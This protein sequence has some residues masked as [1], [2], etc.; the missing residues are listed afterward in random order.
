MFLV[1][2]TGEIARR[3]YAAYKASLSPERLRFIDV[4]AGGD[5]TGAGGGRFPVVEGGAVERLDQP[6]ADVSGVI[7]AEE[8]RNIRPEVMERLV[9]MHFQ[10]M[11]VYTLES[12]YETQWRRVPVRNI[13]PSWP[14][15]IGFQLA[16]EFAVCA[17][18]AV[19]RRGGFRRGVAGVQPGVARA[20]DVDVA[21][22]WPAGVVPAAARGPGQP[23]VH[24][25]QVPHD[26]QLAAARR[27]RRT[28]T[29]AWAIRASRGWATGCA[30]CVWTSC[31]S[32]FNV[33][34]GDMSLIGPRAE[35]TMCAERYE[36]ASRVIISG[37]WSNRGSPAG[38]R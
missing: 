2:G 35:W 22:Q 25:L 20:G 4:P 12:F 27:G 6:G 17:H 38:R 19:V 5:G 13:D 29:R 21:G 32:L 33:L 3:F 15:Q 10:Q 24:H 11:P 8:T 26:V 34:K 30:S 28:C 7:L 31:R 16:R 14:L 1:L 36:Q 9:R 23:D 37:I 18:Q